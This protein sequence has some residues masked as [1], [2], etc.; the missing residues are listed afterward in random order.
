MKITIESDGNI[1]K[2]YRDGV[3]YKQGTGIVFYAK[4]GK[5]V[6]ILEE[7]MLDENGQYI[8]RDGDIARRV[9]HNLFSEG[10]NE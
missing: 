7:Y 1:T 4:P 5:G 10:D 9:H 2:V 3:E 6:C 8:V